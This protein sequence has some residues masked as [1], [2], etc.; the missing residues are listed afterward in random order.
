MTDSHWEVVNFLRDYYNEY[1]IAPAVRVLTKAIGKQLGAGQGQQQVP[2]R[3]VPLRPGQAGL[4]DRRPAEADRLRLSPTR[5]Q[6]SNRAR[7]DH[8]AADRSCTPRCSTPPPP[9]LVVGLGAQDR[10]LRAHA[11]AA[12][13][14]DH[15]GAAHRQRRGP[16]HDARSGVLREPVQLQQVD[17]DLRLD[18]SMSRCC[19]CCCATCATSRSRCGCRWLGSSPSALYAGFAMVGRPGR[20]V[21]AALPGGPRA[22]HLHAVGP[23]D[24]GAAAGHRPDRAGHALRRPHRHRR[25]QGLHARPDALRS[26]AAARRPGAAAASGAGGA[27]DD[28]LPDQQA[29]ARAGRCSSARHA[30]RPTTRARRAISPPGPRRWTRSR[31]EP[32]PPPRS[33]PP[34][35]RSTRSSRWCRSGAMAHSKPY[36]AAAP[37]QKAHRLPRRTGRGLARQGHRQDGRA[38]RQVPLAEGLHGRL[39]A[40][41]RLLRQVPLLPRHRRPEEHAGGAPGPDAQGLPPPLHL[42]RQAFPQAGRRRGPDAR[43]AGRLVQLLQPVLGM[44]PLLGVLPLRHRHRRDHHGRQGDHGLHR[45]GAEVQQRDHRQGAQ[46]RQQP[47]HPRPGAGRHAC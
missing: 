38:A 19:W 14:P 44:P 43:G 26:A 23:P 2:V 1:Q 18:A 25:R 37:I 10:R 13:D 45:H 30:T 15:A 31:A 40:L 41:R 8:V 39:R 9:L 16:A 47:G 21:G 27:A 35:S 29:A 22:L 17:L 34:S 12:E 46:D 28:R 3:A 33:R 20:P 32:W 6:R 36:V 7:A 42:R 5:A 24:A 11:G 4:Q